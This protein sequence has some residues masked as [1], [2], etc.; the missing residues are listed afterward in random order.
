M[1]PA[2]LTG[3]FSASSRD[4]HALI[5]AA[6]CASTVVELGM[7]GFVA[8]PHGMFHVCIETLC[9]NHHR[10]QVNSRDANGF[11]ISTMWS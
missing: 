5:A 8:R 6:I 7:G 11:S 10:C 4:E 9:Q 2:H 1:F 3:A